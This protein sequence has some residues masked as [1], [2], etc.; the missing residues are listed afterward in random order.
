MTKQKSIEELISS[1]FNLV[2]EAKNEYESFLNKDLK[3]IDNFQNKNSLEIEHSNFKIKN[4][5]KNENKST[6]QSS[7][8]DI[9][10][11]N[12]NEIYSK[13][14]ELNLQNNQNNEKNIEAEFNELMQEWI[15][16]NLTRIIEHEFSKY[17]KRSKN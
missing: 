13:K 1:I 14:K 2:S 11:K 6:S 15:N 17:I 8:Q 5:N 7:W 4:I 3:I 10:F 12:T 9:E 16:K